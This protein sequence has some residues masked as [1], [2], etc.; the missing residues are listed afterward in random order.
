MQTSCLTSAIW[1]CSDPP[2]RL[3]GARISGPDPELTATDH[4]VQSVAARRRHGRHGHAVLDQIVSAHRQALRLVKRCQKNGDGP[5]SPLTN[6]LAAR[7][8][9]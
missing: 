2:Q 8:R 5:K 3:G 6:L 7:C 4:A 1:L 9:R